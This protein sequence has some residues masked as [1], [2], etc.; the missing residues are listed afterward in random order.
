MLQS[1]A[2]SW[3]LTGA[4]HCQFVDV[5]WWIVW[6]WHEQIWIQSHGICGDETI[7]AASRP[8]N[9]IHMGLMSDAAE[10]A[11]SWWPTGAGSCQFVDGSWQKVLHWHEQIWTKSHG[12]CGNETISAAS[13]PLNILH[14]GLMSDAAEWCWLLV[15]HE[16]GVMLILGLRGWL[17][18]WHWHEQIWTKV[19]GFVV[20]KPYQ[21]PPDP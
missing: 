6:H 2:G 15:A 10:W 17:K 21:L 5:S 12:I 9:I 1:G 4:G 8:L 13:R 3:W 11:G 18:V 7:S 20:M 14:M 16:C 19:M